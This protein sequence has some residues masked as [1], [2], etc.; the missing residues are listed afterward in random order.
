MKKFFNVI[1]YPV[2]YIA[3]I[4]TCMEAFLSLK[5]NMKLFFMISDIYGKIR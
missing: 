3:Y 2:V 4:L 1:K 5:I